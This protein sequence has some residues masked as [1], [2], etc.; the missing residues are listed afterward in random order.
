MIARYTYK[1]TEGIMQ[2]KFKS[3]FQECITH[4]IALK[5]F[6][7]LSY[8]PWLPVTHVVSVKH[9]LIMINLYIEKISTGKRRYSSKE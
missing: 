3:N 1:Y 4:T 8:D 7:S 9:D 6:Y 5:L 2:K